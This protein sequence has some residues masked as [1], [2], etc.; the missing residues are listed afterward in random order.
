MKFLQ[1]Q[2]WGL[3]SRKNNFDFAIDDL[4]NLFLGDDVSAI[5]Y[6]SII[7]T[8]PIPNNWFWV[9]TSPDLLASN[10]NR[11]NNAGVPGCIFN[12]RCN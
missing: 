3:K 5:R 9:I 12:T 6:Y 11:N 1:S 4:Q 8:R 7:I 2:L 10:T